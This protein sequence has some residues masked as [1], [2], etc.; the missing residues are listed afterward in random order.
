MPRALSRLT[1]EDGLQT[2]PTWSPDG[3]FIAYASDQSGNFDIWVQ[4]IAGGRAVQVTTDPATDWQPV[5]SPDGN[6]LAFRSER[7]GGGIFVVPALG[8]REHRLTTLGYWPEWSPKKSELLF[9]DKPPTDTSGSVPPVYLV[10]LEG[11]PAKRILSDVLAGFEWVGRITWHPDGERISFLGGRGPGNGDV[12]PTVFWTV[13]LTGVAPVRADVSDTVVRN[14]KGASLTGPGNPRWAPAG[15][16]LYLEVT[17]NG[18]GIF[19]RS[20]SIQRRCGGCRDR[21]GSQPV[22]GPTPRL[23]RLPMAGN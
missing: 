5:W 3:R 23:R 11:A 21:S 13:P 4:P 16:E 1:F 14:L 7:D 18:L 22:L 19:G 10:G 2:Q 8:G 17:S 15:D 9:V 20:E 12:W 6:T